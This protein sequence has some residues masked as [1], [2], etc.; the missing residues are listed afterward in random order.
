MEKFRET[1]EYVRFVQACENCRTYRYLGVCV[2]N[3]GVGKT[4]AAYSYSRWDRMEPLVTL[5]RG[6]VVSPSSPLPETAYY[7]AK[8][9]ITPKRLEQDL[10][11]LLLRL[12][13]IAASVRKFQQEEQPFPDAIRFCLIDEVDSLSGAGLDVLRDLFDRHRLGLMLLVRPENAKRLFQHQALVSRRGDLHHFRELDK[14][15]ESVLIEERL[16]Q[17]GFTIDEQGRELLL[18]KTAGN[19][20]RID[21]VLMHFDTLAQGEGAGMLTSKMVEQVVGRLFGGLDE[22]V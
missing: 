21:H 2:G 8:A 16:Q 5:E 20:S 1:T 3:A 12:Q 6:A 13:T 18:K 14:R 11:L 19:F 10:T 4:S 17:M 7:A 9:G 22:A 15:E